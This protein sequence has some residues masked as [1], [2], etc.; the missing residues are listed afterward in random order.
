MSM[1]N[2]ENNTI[3]APSGTGAHFAFHAPFSA[4]KW[5]YAK[6]GFVLL[7]VFG[8]WATMEAGSVGWYVAAILIG[9]FLIYLG[10][11]FWRHG[12]RIEMDED[13]VTWGWRNPLKPDSGIVARSRRME[14]S[15]LSDIRL[16]FFSRKPQSEQTGWMMVQ[17]F[18]K[19]T[20]GS[21]L[22]LTFDG[23]H[24]G[25]QPVLRFAWSLAQQRALPLDEATLANLEAT[26][27]ETAGGNP[28]TS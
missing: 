7:V 21:P 12:L 14:W 8:A 3:D 16:R 13:G 23:D 4:L 22:K 17:I 10:H 18:G 11:T 27:I 15:E 25:F 5:E 24:E 2:I 1:D 6:A 26:G 9:T 19:N 20:D 28:W